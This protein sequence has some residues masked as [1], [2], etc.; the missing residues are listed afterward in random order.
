MRSEAQFLSYQPEAEA[1]RLL[2]P[3][4][5]LGVTVDDDRASVGLDEAHENL[6]ERALPRA[7]LAAQTADFSRVQGK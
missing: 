4:H 3:M 5:V 1:L 6:N 7:V 2:R